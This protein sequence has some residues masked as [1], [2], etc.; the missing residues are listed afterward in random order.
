VPFGIARSGSSSSPNRQPSGWSRLQRGPR[1]LVALIVHIVVGGALVLIDDGEIP[2]RDVAPGAHVDVGA[3]DARPGCPTRSWAV[4]D[5][6]PRA[7]LKDAS[8]TY[9]AD[10]FGLESIYPSRGFRISHRR[11]WVRQAGDALAVICPALGPCKILTVVRD[12]FL[13]PEPTREVLAEADF[14]RAPAGYTVA[15]WFDVVLWE[16][17]LMIVALALISMPVKMRRI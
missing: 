14:Q 6:L 8:Y 9:T 13:G 12:R 10:R 1:V 5:Y 11:L 2:L 16:I 17:P 15:F 3:Y 7:C 4:G